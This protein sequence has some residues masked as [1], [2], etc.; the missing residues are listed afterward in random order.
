MWFLK[1]ISPAFFKIRVHNKIIHFQLLKYFYRHLLL[2][3][4]IFQIFPFRHTSIKFWV[5]ATIKEWRNKTFSFNSSKVEEE[6]SIIRWKDLT[7]VPNL[8][9]PR[10]PR[11]KYDCMKIRTDPL[12]L[13]ID[14][15]RWD[16]DVYFS[17]FLSCLVLINF[18][19]VCLRFKLDHL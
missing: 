11:T 4:G 14:Q 18:H 8:N 6:I 16:F 1:W 10:P 9:T 2:V 3:D 12:V 17:T 15:E 13:E 7:V 5:S 19:T